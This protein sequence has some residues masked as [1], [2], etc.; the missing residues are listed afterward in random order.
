MGVFPFPSPPTVQVSTIK[1]IYNQ[2]QKFFDPSL[3]FIVP[4]LNEHSSLSLSSLLKNETNL[5]LL[6]SILTLDKVI[7]PY[8][9]PPS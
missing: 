3:L 9:P 2:A 5:P 8:F 1:M 4:S 6:Q 7:E